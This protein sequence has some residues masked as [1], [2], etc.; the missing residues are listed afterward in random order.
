[1]RARRLGFAALLAAALGVGPASTAA[2]DENCTPRAS[3]A[4]TARVGEALRSGRDVWGDRLLSAA[5]GPTFAAASR[6]LGP[7][8]YARTV[9]G[10]NLTRSGAYYL[11]FSLPAPAAGAGAAMLHVA[12][13]SEVLA[14]RVTGPALGVAVGSEGR[15]QYGSCFARL[16][17]ARLADGWLPILRTGYRDAGGTRYAQ[18]S[19]TT[20]H[21]RRLTAFVELTA[22][23]GPAELRIGGLSRRVPAD[24]TR[25]LYARWTPPAPAVAIDASAY[26]AARGSVTRYWRARLA[27]GM[28]FDVPEREVRD[29]AR[30]LLTQALTLTWR[31]SY[32]NPYEQ[33]SFPETIDVARVLGEY[34]FEAA[35]RTS[36]RAALPARPTPYPNW[37]MGSKLL[38]FGVHDRLH[39]DGPLLRS[40]TPMLRGFVDALTT[41]QERSGLLPR[42]RF[43]SDVADEV[44]GLHAQATIWRGLHEIA[45]A[46]ARTGRPD[47]ARATRRVAVRLERGLRSAVRRSASPLPD[48]SLFVP[49][50][51]LDD[52][53]PYARATESREASYWNLVAPYALASGLLPRGSPEARGALRYLGLHGTR[54]LGIVRSGAYVLYGAGAGGPRSG[55]NPVYG[56]AATRFL[57]ELD[58][59]DRLVLALYGQLAAGMTPRTFVA[60]EGTTVAPLGGV[61]PRAMYRPPNAAANATFLA[62]LRELLVHER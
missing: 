46:W 19:F 28:R 2:Q 60:G 30:T 62:T 56:N 22:F 57:A 49:M 18:E 25:T 7:L 42:E 5:G 23:G 11:P 34:G 14:R 3:A 8:H 41:R 10:Q 48:G 27:R 9:D 29:G 31:Y 16:V 1:M 54:L 33:V 12:D 50:R 37:K 45:D 40:V 53:P 38:G 61:Y 44:Y 35:A 21:A 4:Y 58:R 13:G 24:A 15:E 26:G 47:L 17:P 32:G 55:V 39:R 20:R 36:L 59:P 51:L 6:H 52:R 43:S